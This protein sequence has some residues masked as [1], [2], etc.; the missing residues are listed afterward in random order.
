[1]FLMPLL[2][3]WLQ[4]NVIRYWIALLMAALRVLACELLNSGATSLWLSAPHYSNVEWHS[5]CVTPSPPT[6]PLPP[7]PSSSLWFLFTVP[8]PSTP[9]PLY[10]C[11]V[12]LS[13]AFHLFPFHART[14]KCRTQG[15]FSSY[16]II[17]ILQVLTAWYSAKKYNIWNEELK[18]NSWTLISEPSCTCIVVIC[19]LG[20]ARE[21]K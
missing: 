11:V 3:C 5:T 7:A 12:I 20:D 17:F 2:Q 9:N 19:P 15:N 6:S 21:S 13:L 16:F 18:K 1:M 8:P 4:F 10:W 14:Q